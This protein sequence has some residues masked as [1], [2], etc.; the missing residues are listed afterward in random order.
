MGDF[1]GGA[2]I[3]LGSL[4]TAI[5]IWSNF[6]YGDPKESFRVIGAWIVDKFGL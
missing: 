4:A 5:A 3:V 1:I 6:K 2:I